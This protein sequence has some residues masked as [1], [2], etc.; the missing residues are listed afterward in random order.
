MRNDL[1][2]RLH[3]RFR[4]A[5]RRG[6]CALFRGRGGAQ[7]AVRVHLQVFAACQQV[8]NA[9]KLAFRS[10]NDRLWNDGFFALGLFRLFC[11]FLGLLFRDRLRF[12]VQLLDEVA[13]GVL[14]GRRDHRL[15]DNRFLAAVLH[16]RLRFCRSGDLA[17]AA[18]LVHKVAYGVFGCGKIHVRD[19]SFHKKSSFKVRLGLPF[20]AST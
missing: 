3:R 12:L 6:L 11:F 5:A 13:H 2:F 14:F 15:R 17:L 9:V 10:G 8:I 20:S 16:F 1:L 4:L 18:D 19:K 7:R